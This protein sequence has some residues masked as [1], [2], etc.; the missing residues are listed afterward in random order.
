MLEQK[1]VTSFFPPM[2]IENHNPTHAYLG[3][4]PRK[5]DLFVKETLETLFKNQKHFCVT[6]KNV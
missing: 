3:G 5:T 1:G 2:L 4:S 6:M